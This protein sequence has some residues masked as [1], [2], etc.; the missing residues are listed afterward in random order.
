MMQKL[1]ALGYMY[2]QIMIILALDAL[3]LNLVKKFNCRNLMQKEY[4]QT[5]PDAGRGSHPR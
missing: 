4:G 5:D 2:G 1:R 3:D